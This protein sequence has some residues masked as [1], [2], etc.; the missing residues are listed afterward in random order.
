MFSTRSCSNFY[1]LFPV[2]ETFFCRHRQLKKKTH[3][4]IVRLTNTTGRLA[5]QMR[6]KQ[7]ERETS[8]RVF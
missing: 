3:E 7:C 1:L 8:P 5:Q 4:G 2:Y 6:S